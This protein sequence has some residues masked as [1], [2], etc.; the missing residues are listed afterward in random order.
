M[1]NSKRRPI[2]DEIGVEIAF[3]I[4]GQ[5]FQVDATLG[6]LAVLNASGADWPVDFSVS[7]A[8]SRISAV[9]TI[10]DP[11]QFAGYD[12]D[13]NADLEPAKSAGRPVGIG[14][15]G[16]ASGRLQVKRER[17]R[18]TSERDY[19]SVGVHR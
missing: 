10:T 1:P 12:L 15:T 13:F 8:G 7:G 4:D 19:C 2:N 11:V 5:E 9:G 14:C 17:W 6:S 3:V 16:A 18:A